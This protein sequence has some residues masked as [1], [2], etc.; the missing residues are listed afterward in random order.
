MKGRKPCIVVYTAD[1]QDRDALLTLQQAAD[2]RSRRVRHVFV[3]DRQA[4]DETARAAFEASQTHVEV[5]K[6]SDEE[7]K[8]FVVVP[9]CWIAGRTFGR[10]SC[11]RCLAE[12]FE[13]LIEGSQ[14][15]FLLALVFL[16]IRPI[17]RNY[18][19]IT[20]FR[21]TRSMSINNPNP[22]GPVCG[23]V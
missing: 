3:E 9:M 4:G 22:G 2:E 12:D 11:A 16:L 8:G 21:I 14:V 6:S 18:A 17:S 10:I 5:A 1:I 20:S 23:I 15:W 19:A 13:T 7:A